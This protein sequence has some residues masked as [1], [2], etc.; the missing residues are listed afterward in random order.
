MFGAAVSVV[1]PAPKG[2]NAADVR[3]AELEELLRLWELL[4]HARGQGAGGEEAAQLQAA[5]A[6][7]REQHEDSGSSKSL[8][9]RLEEAE[10][11]LGTLQHRDS[12]EALADDDDD[13]TRELQALAELQALGQ[14]LGPHFARALANSEAETRSRAASSQSR[15]R[16][17]SSATPR[18][19]LGGSRADSRG[20][21]LADGDVTPGRTEGRRVSFA[22]PE[23][24]S[25]AAVVL[26][27]DGSGA[28][29]SAVDGTLARAEVTPAQRVV[30]AN[31]P[32]HLP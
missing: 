23:G 26:L 30:P 14:R 32:L 17:T 24:A 25:A 29:S 3:A 15:S 13:C 22:G 20:V 16:A 4:V 31:L 6:R 27:A 9:D 5:I 1:V 18:E 2:F 28:S 10:T 8:K 7:A 11:M 12:R 21:S 19:R